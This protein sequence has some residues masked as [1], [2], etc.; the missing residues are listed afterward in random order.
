MQRRLLYRIAVALIL[1]GLLAPAAQ[2]Q[3]PASQPAG[4]AALA[5]IENTGQFDPQARYLVRAGSET[6]WL[7]ADGLWLTHMQPAADVQAPRQGVHLH[8]RF[9][10]ANPSPQI[11]PFG[12]QSTRFS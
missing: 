11:E 6:L 4:S 2:A 8:L 9:P 5:F 3:Q 12:R 7:T 10:G 1:A